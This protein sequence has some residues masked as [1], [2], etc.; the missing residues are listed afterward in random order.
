MWIS[1]IF[2]LSVMSPLKASVAMN[3]SAVYLQVK[4][5]HNPN[6]RRLH[7]NRLDMKQT[8][9]TDSRLQHQYTTRNKGN[10]KA[11]Y[12]KQGGSHD[13]NNPMG[14]KTHDLDNQSE[15]DTSNRGTNSK[16]TWGQGKHDTNRNRD[17]T[18][19]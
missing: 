5:K 17:E 18:S 10:D 6:R 16:E 19:K 4:S 11:T 2:S 14:N 3:P 7:L 15:H 9:L 1:V 12:N 8:R 13:K